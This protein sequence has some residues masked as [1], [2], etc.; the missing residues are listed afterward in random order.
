MDILQIL[1]SFATVGGLGILFGVILAFAAKKLAV[2][3]DERVTLVEEALPGINCGTCGF[4]GCSAYAEAI[5]LEGADVTLCAPGGHGTV[6]T[7]A[8]IMKLDIN[9]T[10]EK[11]VARNHCRGGKKTAQY[12][13]SYEGV[14]DCNA[15][16]ALYGG[17]KVCSH[18]CL[19]QG[20]CV[21]VCPVDAINYDDDGLVIVDKDICIS[22]GQCLEVCPTGVMK[23]VPYYG[24]Y[25]VACNSTD[26]GAAVKRYCSVG[27]IGCKLCVKA[28]PEGGFEVENFLAKIDYSQ[29]GERESAAAKCPPKCIIKNG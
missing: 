6:H 16:Y 13:F 5:V 25:I 14:K 11:Q 18:G 8:Q 27:C 7:L 9:V 17:N 26:K 19:G 1:A 4:A 3:K 12:K 21:K 10:N 28:S 20:S 15:M 24:D 29:K 23:M 22:C 2:E